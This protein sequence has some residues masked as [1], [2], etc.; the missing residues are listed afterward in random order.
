MSTTIVFTLTGT[1]RIG[2]VDEV[3]GSLL[4]IGGNIQAS[5]MARLGGEF[6]VIMLVTLPVDSR[7]ALE[8]TVADLTRRGY[9]VTTS[10][11]VKEGAAAHHG[12]L[13]YSIEVRGADHQ[14]IVNRIAHTLSEHGITIE[15]AD[16]G[17]T[18]APNSGIPLFTMRAEVLAP[19][20]LEEDGWRLALADV[21]Q[22]EHVDISIETKA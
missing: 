2:I 14:G 1:D 11:T 12:W 13:P 9:K 18:H 19:P 4:E 22:E 10:E 3:T 16:T 20:N 21:A 6:A 17:S 7:T 15:T 8:R 5:R